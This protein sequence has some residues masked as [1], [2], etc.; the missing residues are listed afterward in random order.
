MIVVQNKTQLVA[1]SKN[2]PLREARKL[3][4]ESYEYTLG[5]IEASALLK[6]KISIIDQ[7]LKVDGK[8]YDLSKFR[9]IFVIGGGKAG[10]SMSRALEELM[11]KWITCGIVNVPKGNIL[12][13]K[14]IILNQASHPLPNQAGVEGSKKMLEIAKQATEDDLIICL[15]SGGGS[16]LMPLPIEGISIEDKQEVT[17]VLLKSGAKI[18][19]VNTVRKHLSCLKGGFLAKAAYPAT[20][21]NFIISDVVGD[22]LGSIASGP[23]V[24]DNT[25]FDDAI[26]ILKK[27]FLWEKVPLSVRNILTK[28]E[29]GIIDETPK[30]NSKFFKKVHNI[31]IGNN[32]VACLAVRNFFEAQGIATRLL[33]KAIEG[34]AR[35]VGAT[36]ALK[37]REI[38]SDS[39]KK[40]FC[41]IAGGETTVTVKG[42]GIGGRNQELSLAATIMLNEF[43]DFVF[44]SLTTDGIDGSTHAAGAICDG[45]TLKRASSLNLNP[46]MFLAEN[47]SYTFFHKLEDLVFTGQTGTNVNDIVISLILPKSYR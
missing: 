34:E 42:R 16:S 47:D 8:S 37:I 30:P 3:V 36:L 38:S 24:P 33:E 27:Y 46:E 13:T 32:R 45:D 4:L 20:L 14:K 43:T 17:Q 23:T 12:K 5:S 40:P 29:K 25:T 41:L 35:Q 21:L 11:A 28:G 22:E 15:I 26:S 7:V 1:K 44:A 6:S 2:E 19:E 31:I 9:K 39:L 10:A 18:N